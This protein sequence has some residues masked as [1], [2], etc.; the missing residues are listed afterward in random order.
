M[1]FLQFSLLFESLFFEA[2]DER[3]LSSDAEDEAYYIHSIDTTNDNFEAD[4]DSTDVLKYGK[5]YARYK[6]KN[7]RRF[8]DSD[9]SDDDYDEDDCDHEQVSD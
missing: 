9:Y 8:N 7:L 2:D 3:E 1:I 5:A 4:I 6:A